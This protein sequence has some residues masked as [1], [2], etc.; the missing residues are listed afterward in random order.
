MASNGYTNGNPA[1]DFQLLNN[2]LPSLFTGEGHATRT[3]DWAPPVNVLE[4]AEGLIVTAEVPGMSR[5]EIEIELENGLLVVRGSRPETV[6]EE[7]RYRVRERT[8]GAFQRAFRMPHWV[9]SDRISAH[10]ERG[11]LSITLPKAAAAQPRRIEISTDEQ[12]A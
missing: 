7:G 12:S 10:L 1:L 6:G 2:R 11:V 4:T 5:E 9:E 8:C 3:G